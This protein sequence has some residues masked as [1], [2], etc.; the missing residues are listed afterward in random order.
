M[1][2][3]PQQHA[4][5]GTGGDPAA[6]TPDAAES[7]AADQGLAEG[8]LQAA[9]R[10]LETVRER[11]GERIREAGRL[12][13]DTVE[14]GGRLFAFGAGHSS[15]PAQDL[16]YRAGGLA[17]WN[18]LG[19]PGAV[20]VD[21]RP[22]TLGSALELVDGLASTVLDQSPAESGDLLVVISLSGRNPLPVEMAAHARERGLRVVAVTSL[23]YADSTRSRHSSGTFLKD[24]AD[25]VID[26]QVAVGDAELSLEGVDAPFGPASTVVVSAIMQAVTASAAGTLRHRGITPPLLRSGNV[27]GGHEWNARLMRSYRD[28]LYYGH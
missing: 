22:A 3:R 20:G 9:V 18:L 10:L 12:V 24:H 21:V 15:L 28:R 5:P 7:R 2:A 19:V 13:A 6:A 14:N 4:E 17:V 25:L 8:Y 23:A 1:D 11:E 26:N 16:V 27:D